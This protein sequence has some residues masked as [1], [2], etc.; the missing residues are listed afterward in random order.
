MKTLAVSLNKKT[1]VTARIIEMGIEIK[2]ITQ[3]FEREISFCSAAY[4]PSAA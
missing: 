4:A 1:K 3:V 2:I